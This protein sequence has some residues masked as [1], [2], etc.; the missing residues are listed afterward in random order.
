MA[1]KIP[2]RGVKPDKLMRDAIIVALHREARAS[3]AGKTTKLARIADALVDKAMDGQMDAIKE[4]NNRVDG[5]IGA[6]HGEQSL[7]QSELGGMRA[8]LEKK[9]DR[10]A[11]AAG[12]S[13]AEDEAL[14]R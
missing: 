1:A 10:I 6:G 13:E 12:E 2:S 8:S 4:I 9:L 11:A 3:G 5:K 7:L 14:G